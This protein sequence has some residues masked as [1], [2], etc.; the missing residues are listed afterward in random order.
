MKVCVCPFS[1]CSQC[2]KASEVGQCLPRLRVRC[3]DFLEYI[4]KLNRSKFHDKMFV[5]LRALIAKPMPAGYPNRNSIIAGYRQ[6]R[7]LS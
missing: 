6:R 5:E 4:Q 7:V 1:P 2:K 3:Q